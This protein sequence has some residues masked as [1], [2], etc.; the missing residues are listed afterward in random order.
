MMPAA[1]NRYERVWAIR[2]VCI[3]GSNNRLWNDHG[4]VLKRVVRQGFA[5]PTKIGLSDV[6]SAWKWI[7][8]RKGIDEGDDDAVNV[9]EEIAERITT[10]WDTQPDDLTYQSDG[11]IDYLHRHLCA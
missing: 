7:R 5:I 9:V 6:L 1:R 8:E 3:K 10:L 11:C 4:D 2:R